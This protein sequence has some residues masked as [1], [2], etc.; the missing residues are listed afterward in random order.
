MILGDVGQSYGVGGGASS[1]AVQQH[2]LGS[3]TR[4]MGATGQQM[5]GS[6]G[7][8]VQQHQNSPMAQMGSPVFVT[9]PGSLP[10]TASNPASV[11]TGPASVSRI[12][13][14]TTP[15]DTSSINVSQPQS[16]LPAVQFP[17]QQS[18][19][20]PGLLFTYIKWIIF[21]A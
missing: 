17:A 13:Q 21:N 12:D 16:S 11:G 10:Q 5:A 4:P 2:Q 3:M 15:M 9:G 8:P 7:Y 14:P 6:Y 1:M 20:P 19:I 18:K